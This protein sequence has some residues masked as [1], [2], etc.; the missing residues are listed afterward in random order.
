[1]HNRRYLPFNLILLG[2]GK[3][4]SATTLQVEEIL[5]FACELAHLAVTQM[6]LGLQTNVG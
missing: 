5:N 4:D 6:W 1:M 3:I 2:G